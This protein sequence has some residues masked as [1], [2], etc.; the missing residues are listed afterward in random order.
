M[1]LSKNS[2]RGT[3]KV[4]SFTLK[5]MVCNRANI[6]SLAVIFLII[7]CM[8]PVMTLISGG[9]DS[10]ETH[11]SDEI[12]G[13]ESYEG[14][15]DNEIILP[16][17][18]YVLNETPFEL[19]F[20]SDPFY[21][22]AEF[23]PTSFSAD[24]YKEILT[25][26]EGF[27]HIYLT[28]SGFTIDCDSPAADE[29]AVYASYLLDSAV[30]SSTD[31][32]EILNTP[33]NVNSYTALE[34][35]EEDDFEMSMDSYGIQLIYSIVVMLVSIYAASFIVQSVVEEKT[36]KLVETLMISVKPLALILGKIF[37]AMLYVFGIVSLNII[38]AVLSSFINK[39]IFGDLGTS[40]A[41]EEL[42]F[43]FSD[44]NFTPAT[45]VIVIVS[46]LLGYLTYSLIAGMT[47]AG[48]SQAEEIQ[49]ANSTSMMIVMWCYIVA[50]ITT[51]MQSQAISIITSVLPFL[52]IFCAPV[53]YMM[54]NIGFGVLLA[55]WVIQIVV[56]A[57]LAWMCAKIYEDLI[58][59][60]GKRLTFIQIIKM[61]FAKKNKEVA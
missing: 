26:N 30:N 52:S 12:L 54:G 1:K 42:G 8:M 48:C 60:K 23:V 22:N 15:T 57:F 6:I 40:A 19:D 18:V 41:M 37:A 29:I 56:I 58:I 53:Q 20:S 47:G 61:A 9:A 39:A 24:A 34:Y 3:G 25:E 36:S 16:E 46:L 49:S 43:S 5:Q 35:N 21:A 28:E 33:Y 51:M 59:Y 2:F 27:L 13:S 14:D 31:T 38:A 11:V 32:A 44:L 10:S 45:I 50:L 4:F 7:L 55:A 17:K